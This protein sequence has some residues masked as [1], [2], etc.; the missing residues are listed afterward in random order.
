[1]YNRAP[2][3]ISLNFK[4]TIPGVDPTTYSIDSP[5]T[6]GKKLMILS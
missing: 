4:E 5:D 3:D 6:R 2:R 1:M